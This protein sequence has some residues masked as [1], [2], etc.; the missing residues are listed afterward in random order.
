MSSSSIALTRW[1]RSF[2][3]QFWYRRG[4]NFAVPG[5]GRGRLLVLVVV[6]A[7]VV[8]VRSV[9]FGEGFGV[10]L[11]RAL[12]EGAELCS[13]VGS[14]RGSGSSGARGAGCEADD[15]AEE[16]A[17]EAVGICSAVGDTEFGSLS[18]PLRFLPVEACGSLSPLPDSCL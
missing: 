17:D 1:P 16:L 5:A 10:V 2:G 13:A 8:G 18:S 3:A 14:C 4:I 7:G 9:G 6:V 15:T 12:V 11:F